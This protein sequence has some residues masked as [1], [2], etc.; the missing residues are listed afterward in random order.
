MQV[1]VVKFSLRHGR[2]TL[3]ILLLLL[4][5]RKQP[6]SYLKA[7]AGCHNFCRWSLRRGEV[8]VNQLAD[9]NCHCCQHAHCAKN[10]DSCH[11]LHLVHLQLL[12]SQLVSSVS[13]VH[14]QLRQHPGGT[15]V[16]KTDS[17]TMASTT[18]AQELLQL[19]LLPMLTKQCLA[20]SNTPFLPQLPL[21]N[22]LLG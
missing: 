9:H 16:R 10:A 7:C 22:C 21:D 12:V 14:L 20:L 19:V 17:V 2:T 3:I 6:F 4:K 18:L 5:I 13:L 1:L 15:G 8:D 11:I